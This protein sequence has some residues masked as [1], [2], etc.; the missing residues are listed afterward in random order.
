M[1]AVALTLTLALV[2]ALCASP[3]GAQ[4]EPEWVQADWAA[5]TGSGSVAVDSRGGVHVV[6][7]NNANRAIDYSF[8]LDGRLIRTSTVGSGPASW[9]RLALGPGDSP[10]VVY[11]QMVADTNTIV[12]A[13]LEAGRWTPQTLVTDVSLLSPD[14]RV[15]SKGTV[16]VAAV[17]E[18]AEGENGWI[19]VL[20]N[21]G[22]PWARESFTVPASGPVSFARGLALTSDERPALAVAAGSKVYLAEREPS[23]WV[24][25]EVADM[26]AMQGAIA[27][28]LVL[29]PQGQ[30]LVI[31]EVAGSDW[32]EVWTAE[33]G[34]SGW[35]GCLLA[36]SAMQPAGVVDPGGIPRVVYINSIPNPGSPTPSL[37][38]HSYAYRDPGSE[39]WVKALLPPGPYG[40]ECRHGNIVVGAS[41]DRI[42]IFRTL[43]SKGQQYLIR[44]LGRLEPAATQEGTFAADITVA[45]DGTL[46]GFDVPPVIVDGRVLVPLRVIFEALG[47]SVDW[48]T[49][50]RT[51]TAV[52]RDTI[53][54]LEIGRQTAYISDEPVALD[55]AAQI[56]DG[57]TLVPLRF[58]AEAL[59]AAVAWN[60]VTRSITI[61]ASLP[62]LAVPTEGVCLAAGDTH[63]L[64]VG[65]DGTVWAWGGN[66]SG[67][68]G[69]GTTAGRSTPAPVRGLTDI[70]SVS[71]AGYHTV[72]LRRDGTAWTWGPN[73]YGQLGDGTTDG[74][75]TPVRVQGLANVVAVAA[76][77]NRTVALRGDGTV[78]AWGCNYSGQLGDGTTANRSTPVQVPGLVDVVAVAAGYDH[79]VALRRDGT[80]WSWGSNY[81]GQLG[82]GT[83]TNRSAPVQVQGLVD[84]VGVTAGGWHTVALRRDGT[85]WAWGANNLGQLG[86]GTTTDR[87]TPV[88][89]P[90]LTDVATVSA[91]SYHTVALR[92][93]GTVWTWGANWAGQLGDGT[94]TG[95]TTPVQVTGLTDVVAVAAGATAGG[96]WTGH[97]V[98]LRSDGTVWA[99]GLNTSGQL[100]DGTTAGWRSTP[101]QVQGA[102]DV[103]AASAGL[104]H[105]VAL[106]RD[107]TVWT[108]G[109]NEY[110]QLGDGTTTYR[111]AAAQVPGLT[112]VAAVAAWF[113][114]TVALR[115]DGTVWAWGDNV[116]GQLGDGTKT[117]RSTPVQTQ[118]LTDVIAV[119]AGVGHTVAL[120]RDGTVWTWG[121]NTESQLGGSRTDPLVPGQV[122]KLT[123]VV[124]VAAGSYHTVALRGD[125][126]VWTWGWNYS[127]Q[128]GDGTT[129]SRLTPVQVTGLTNAIAVAAAYGHTVVVRADGTVWTWGYNYWGELGDGT[130]GNRSAPVQ[131]RGLTD[132]VAVAAGSGHTVALR[133]DG[134]VWT[135]GGNSSGQL[136]DGTLVRRLAPVQARGL[137]DVTFVSAGG[138]YTVAV[139]RDGTVW[140]W[141]S[142]ED[143]QLGI[144][145]AFSTE[146]VRAG[147]P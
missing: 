44:P 127:G 37:H 119:A 103:I 96:G 40:R 79:T 90:G 122:E 66:S 145:R 36:V 124:A 58:V 105:A 86:D 45:V 81:S 137:T 107:G 118:G 64:A 94:T 10:V 16:I 92:R 114:H 17:A 1:R 69:D 39:V 56:R 33:R 2:M 46:L 67:Q 112:D 76:G 30:P 29:Y 55:V 121:K 63:T 14:I 60:G 65:P 97:A 138:G 101:A 98:A 126:T 19:M 73:Y 15:T 136:G 13:S 106:G 113:L 77:S 85:V 100:G 70:V 99:W 87:T 108:W 5:N 21:E 116:Y 88:Q 34:A 41:V 57:R 83:T 132:V 125:G 35:T 143:G 120:R 20:T 50:T 74:R 22:G 95:R 38:D 109:R 131:V 8:Y 133:R 42:H 4:T 6:W 142:N 117:N 91:G 59:G 23:G 84:V 32:A 135:W 82:D 47:A 24:T 68:L 48:N 3:V 104:G 7:G 31:Y 53:I 43:A 62:A 78:W 51:I 111:S 140:A 130:T 89:V 147:K 9:P 52:R 72:A 11:T 93:D 80:V 115:R 123:G 12:F 49:A 110:G 71:A 27:S 102:A 75:L 61:T 18:V 128:L 25:E 134:T 141:G 26:G 144:P 139:R 54:R 129:D 146:P 28:A